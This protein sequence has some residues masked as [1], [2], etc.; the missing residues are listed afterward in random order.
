LAALS[1]VL[2]LAATHHWVDEELESLASLAVEAAI[3]GCDQNNRSSAGHRRLYDI[4]R[5]EGMLQLY[6]LSKQ[7]HQDG[8]GLY[9]S[10]ALFGFASGVARK[11][12]PRI[13]SALVGALQS[14]DR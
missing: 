8:V 14:E 3:D 13:R 4:G 11:F 9:S 10:K 12:I 1:K 5:I 6:R 7:E 2:Q